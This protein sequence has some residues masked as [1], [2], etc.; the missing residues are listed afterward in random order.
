MAERMGEGGVFGEVGIE[1]ILLLLRRALD[2]VPNDG[3]DLLY[4][5]ESSVSDTGPI[6]QR[7]KWVGSN[8]DYPEP[9][10]QARAP[11]LANV[12]DSWSLCGCCAGV[13]PARMQTSHAYLDDPSCPG[14]DMEW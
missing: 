12:I 7:S 10:S 3:S 13:V 14:S 1:G 5:R 8:I 11:L 2:Q 9:L 6:R 4:C